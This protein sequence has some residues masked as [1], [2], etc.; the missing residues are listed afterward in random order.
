MLGKKAFIMG[1]KVIFCRIGSLIVVDKLNIRVICYNFSFAYV[2]NV[3]E[4]VESSSLQAV[5]M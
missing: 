2:K 5:G 3:I 4:A 1:Y